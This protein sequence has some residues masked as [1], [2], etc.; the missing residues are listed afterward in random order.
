MV[1]RQ[2]PFFSVIVPFWLI[3]A[4]RGLP[5][6]D[7]R[8]ARVLV[9]GVAFA[10]P[11]FLVS[12]FHGPWLVDIVASVVSMG[13]LTL[14]LRVWQPRDGYSRPRRG[15][16]PAPVATAPHAAS[17]QV[18]P[19]WMPWIILSVLVFVVGLPQMKA[20]LDGISVVRIPVPGCTS[21]SASRRSSRR[22]PR[23]RGVQPQLAVGHGHGILI[24]AHR[25]AGHHGLLDPRAA[26]HVRRT[27]LLVRRRS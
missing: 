9:A 10:V 27:L 12:N 22:R 7:A 21:S 18:M 5:R 19:A 14:L 23:S 20:A 24:A 17:G 4:L 8:V 6:D 2:L 13:A 3:W 26:A 16:G 15:N 11:Q 25:R 1:G